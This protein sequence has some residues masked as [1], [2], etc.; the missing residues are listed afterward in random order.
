M[1]DRLARRGSRKSWHSHQHLEHLSGDS[2][3]LSSLIP[4]EDD[5]CGV[6]HAATEQ[7]ERWE[8]KRGAGEK[9]IK[10]RNRSL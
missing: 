2:S 3:T 8:A 10:W 1:T 6:P 5:S 7:G 4:R 9:R